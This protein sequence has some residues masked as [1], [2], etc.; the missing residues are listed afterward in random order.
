M[1]TSLNLH[2]VPALSEPERALLAAIE[3][4]FINRHAAARHRKETA[5]SELAFV[6][7]LFRFAGTPLWNWTLETMD[8]YGAWLCAR[9]ATLET[10][11]RKQGAIRR[12]LRYARASEYPWNA[13]CIAL[14]GKPIPQICVPEN[15]VPHQRGAPTSKRRHFT[16]DE[17]T[18]L[19]EH[20][21][22]LMN[23]PRL[24]IDYLARA[25]HYVILYFALGTG[26][27]AQEIAMGDLPD[28][29]P[30]TTPTIAAYSPYE[31]FYVRFGKAH[32]GGPARQRTIVATDVFA[33][34]FQ[35]LAWYIDQIRPQLM[36]PGSPPAIFLA[37]SGQRLRPGSIS[38][39]FGNYRTA[40]G[41]SRDLT[42]HCFRHHFVTTL[43]EHNYRLA[44]MRALLGHTCDASTLI[45]DHTSPEFIKEQIVAHARA[46]R[47]RCELWKSTRGIYTIA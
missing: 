43:R 14:T 37:R 32:N 41:L 26:A 8:R 17:L 13:R 2:V 31:D 28:L 34:A 36:R 19:F 47:R 35:I 24:Y 4:G 16:N 12:F 22:R 45:Y 15:T 42:L 33:D 46:T 18:A 23:Q 38:E 5:L 39:L 6:H 3:E 10:M 44:V 30:A 27:R 9:N 25:T 1:S 7:E 20:V 40:V 29:H 21:F 11:R